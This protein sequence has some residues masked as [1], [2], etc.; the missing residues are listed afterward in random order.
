L[1]NKRGRS[2]TKASPIVATHS[3]GPVRS[4]AMHTG[5]SMRTRTDT[6]TH[7]HTH[8]DKHTNVHNVHTRAQNTHAQTYTT[9]TTYTH[10]RKTYAQ[11]RTFMFRT[12]WAGSCRVTTWKGSNV[13]D[14]RPQPSVGHTTVL[15]YC[16]CMRST[17]ALRFRSWCFS[18]ARADATAW[19]RSPASCSK[20]TGSNDDGCG[21]YGKNRGTTCKNA[22]P[23]TPNDPPPSA[24]SPLQNNEATEGAEKMHAPHQ[25]RRQGKIIATHLR[26]HIFLLLHKIHVLMQTIQHEG[27]KLLKKTR[28]V[29]HGTASARFCAG[30][31]TPPSSIV[32]VHRERTNWMP[33]PTWASCCAKPLNCLLKVPMAR[34]TPMGATLPAL[35]SHISCSKP[36]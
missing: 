2:K 7:L 23:T 35:P 33:T 20:Y 36:A 29:A 1:Q 24:R 11:T 9:Y 10:A 27:Q 32:G 13:T 5:G 16:P 25:H 4:H 21:A 30:P 12:L 15:R 26:L 31:P 17:T 34:L 8:T 14:T 22:H 28:T 18:H 3:L 6:H 19:D